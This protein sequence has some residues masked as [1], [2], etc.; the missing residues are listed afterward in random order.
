M[1]S[2]SISTSM[3]GS[4]SRETSTRDDAGRM[5]LKT[6]PC[7]SAIVSQSRMLVT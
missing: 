2:A 1:A 4:I 5:P 7:A 3:S 6:S